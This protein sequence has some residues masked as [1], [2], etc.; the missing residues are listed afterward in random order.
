VEEELS[1]EVQAY[2]EVLIEIKIK[3]GLQPAAA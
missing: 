2:L 3:E 1:E